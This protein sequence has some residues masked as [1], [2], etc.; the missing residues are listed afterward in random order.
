MRLPGNKIF[1]IRNIEETGHLYSG[2]SGPQLSVY[3]ISTSVTQAQ[4]TRLLLVLMS[5]PQP[6]LLRMRQDKEKAFPSFRLEGKKRV[7]DQKLG[8]AKVPVLSQSAA[9]WPVYQ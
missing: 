3:T 8:D 4:P 9:S 7:A 6:A 1:P 5:S 2:T